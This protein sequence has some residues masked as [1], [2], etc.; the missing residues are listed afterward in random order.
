MLIMS[1]QQNPQLKLAYEFVQHTNKNVF[2]TGKAGTGKTTFLH[3]LKESSPKR[4]VV[5]APTGVAAINAGGVTIHSFFQL[6]FGPH[7]PEGMQKQSSSFNSDPRQSFNNYKKFNRDKIN[8]IKSLDLLVIDE[9]SMVRADMLDAI[10]EVLRRYKNHSKPF[11][12]VQLLL[13]GDLHQLS[14]IV[15]DDEWNILKDYYETI[16]FFSSNALKKSQHV[17][18]ELK[19]I[20]R[21]SDAHFIDLLNQIRNNDIDEYSLTELNERYIPGFKPDDDEG[22]II[23]TTHNNKAQEVNQFKLNNIK[24]PEIAFNADIDADFPQEIFPTEAELLLK[25]GAQVMFV[26]NDTA[27]ER[28]YY[29]GKIGKITHIEDDII[30][31]KC[32]TD[33]FNIPVSRVTWHNV[34]YSLNELTKEIDEKITGSFTQFP[35]KLAWA[36]TI[37]KSQGLTFEK[38]IIDAKSSFAFGQVYV[39]LSRCKS[40]EG[41]VLSSPI[42]YSSIR[43]DQTI[44]EFTN[45]INRNVPNAGHL[46]E[47]KIDFQKSLIFE[48]FDFEEIKKRF[49]IFRKTATEFS[50]ILDTTLFDELNRIDSNARTDI[51]QVA[52]KFKLQ[53]DRLTKEKLPEENIELQERVKKASVFFIDKVDKLIYNNIQNLNIETDNRAVKKTINESLSKLQ[54]EVFIKIGCMKFGLDGFTTIGY[55]RAKANADIDFKESTRITS[56]PKLIVP[57]N[58]EHSELYLELKAWRNAIADENSMPTY[59]VVPYKVLVD[60]A[61]YLPFSIPELEMIK[62]MG[63]AKINQYGEEIIAIITKYCEQ[64]KIEKPQIDLQP[65]RKKEKKP[66]ADPKVLSFELYKE[67]KTISEI[68]QIRGFVNSTIEGHLS[69]YV[70]TGELDVYKFVPKDKVDAITEFYSLNTVTFLGEAKRLLG[71]HISYA[72]IRFVLK[73]LEWNSK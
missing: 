30:Y 32:P 43:N 13:I 67:G 51:Y 15:K 69:H 66:K 40:I 18:I 22:Y 65:V 21:Q 25:E 73:H 4:M 11:G 16:Y 17:N 27:R 61:T 60:L 1:L 71:D 34:K 56:V 7:I 12:G 49:Y 20:F 70:G 24:H 54:R 41:L 50:N 46:E 72:D 57:K 58:L 29:N 8:L 59:M 62:G 33:T 31:V 52:E 9:I 5:V 55:L 44:A 47:A 38:A 48:L 36:I 63:K 35:L 42:L 19:E 6:P 45:D 53:L 68:A 2:L 26:K 23:L 39:A 64:Y 3:N 10:D 28:L 37:H 14:P